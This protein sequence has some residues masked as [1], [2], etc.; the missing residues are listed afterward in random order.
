RR[1][2]VRY[3]PAEWTPTGSH[4]VR[5][6]SIARGRLYPVVHRR[7]V[8][9]VGRDGAQVGLG[10]LSEARRTRGAVHDLGHAPL[11]VV[12]VRLEAGLEQIGDIALVPLSDAGLV[13]GRDVR[14]E[15]DARRLGDAGDEH[16]RAE[17]AEPVARRVAIPADRD[18][19]CQVLPALRAR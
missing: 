11:H 1:P 7:Y 12:E 17:R 2:A 16:L 5:R 4:V 9:Q 6:A 15:L 18:V 14:R 19:L 3:E 8:L 10:R 13:V